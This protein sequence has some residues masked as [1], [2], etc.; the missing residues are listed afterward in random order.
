MNELK[1]DIQRK[2]D[3]LI[4]KARRTGLYENFGDK[5]ERQIK[6]KYKYN[7]LVFGAPEEREK[8]KLIS[9][10]SDWCNNFDQSQI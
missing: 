10:F 6:E 4:K 5:E 2:K 1:N 9:E 8:A 7:D 3:L